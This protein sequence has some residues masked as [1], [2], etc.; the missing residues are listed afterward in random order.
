MEKIYP[1]LFS[2]FKVRQFTFKNRIIA[3]PLG[4]W[5][6]SP[7]NYI[8]DYAIS[9]FEQKALGGAAAVTVGHTEVHAEEEDTDGFGLYFNLR[10]REGTSALSEFAAAIKQHGAHVS[11]QMN[12][13]GD[14]GPSEFVRRGKPL[15]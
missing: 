4:A 12:Y 13:G 8:Y 9:M 10:K 14:Y 5:V 6:F 11:L 7:S 1:H 3:S 2:P 15:G